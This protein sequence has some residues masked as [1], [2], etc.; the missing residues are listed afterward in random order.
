MQ[1]KRAYNY[2]I[3]EFNLSIVCEIQLFHSCASHRGGPLGRTASWDLGMVELHLWVWVEGLFPIAVSVVRSVSGWCDWD[4]AWWMRSW[5]LSPC[6]ASGSV[7]R[8][9]LALMHTPQLGLVVVLTKAH[10]SQSYSNG[11]CQHCQP[12]PTSLFTGSITNICILPATP[13]FPH[14]RLCLLG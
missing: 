13:A 4:V 9:T 2:I 11:L 10:Y 5:K 3:C 12:A 7:S 1:R 14:T 6:C 8:T